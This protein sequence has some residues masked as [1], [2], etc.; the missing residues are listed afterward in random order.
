MGSNILFW[1]SINF[2]LLP[3]A[4]GLHAWAWCK[5]AA[6]PASINVLSMCKRTKQFHG[7]Q[8]PPPWNAE[9]SFM[10]LLL[11]P[12]WTDWFTAPPSCMYLSTIVRPWKL[13]HV[14]SGTWDLRQGKK[15][16]FKWLWIM[17]HKIKATLH[18]RR[19]EDINYYEPEKHEEVSLEKPMQHIKSYYFFCQGD[20]PKV[21]LCS[22]TQAPR[23]IFFHFPF[24]D[25]F[26]APGCLSQTSPN[27][28]HLMQHRTISE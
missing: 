25:A 28:A 19:G 14:S 21:L 22:S 15:F 11:T 16:V 1:C 10:L 7:F 27:R 9:H 6:A 12:R 26:P 2:I 23:S 17:I 8:S 18:K 4:I 20:Q 24:C 5:A 13:V 3:P